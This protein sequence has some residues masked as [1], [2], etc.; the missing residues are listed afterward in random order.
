M[1]YSSTKAGEWDE[2]E[3]MPEYVTNVIQASIDR[4]YVKFVS[5]VADNRDMAIRGCTPNCW[6]KNLGW[7]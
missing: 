1:A 6:W 7:I 5:K 3:A 2:R 4:I